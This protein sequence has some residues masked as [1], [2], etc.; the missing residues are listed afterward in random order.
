MAIAYKAEG[1]G[2]IAISK[3]S[4]PFFKKMHRKISKTSLIHIAYQ[5]HQ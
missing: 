1:Y 4:R 3:E 5:F 2:T